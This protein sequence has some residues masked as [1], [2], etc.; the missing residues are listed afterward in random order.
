MIAIKASSAYARFSSTDEYAARVRENLR[1][2]F[3]YVH[4][5][6][7]NASLDANAEGFIK[8]AYYNLSAALLTAESCGI[9]ES[10]EEI[11]KYTHDAFRD[12]NSA[13]SLQG[14]M[15]IIQTKLDAVALADE[16]VHRV[17]FELC[18]IFYRVDKLE[19]EC[20]ER[21]ESDPPDG[22]DEFVSECD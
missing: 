21:Q 6:R 9:R 3:A 22:Y 19:L 10:A 4:K 20:P 15:T 7:E 11:N 13:S 5:L 16:S 18:N 1:W 2:G 8:R 17:P 12:I 14:M